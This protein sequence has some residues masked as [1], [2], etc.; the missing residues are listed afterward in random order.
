MFLGPRNLELKVAILLNK[1]HAKLRI[2][3][4]KMLHRL[5][6]RSGQV[7]GGIVLPEFDSFAEVLDP[8][9]LF[10]STE[11]PIPWD[12][13]SECNLLIWEW[14]WTSVPAATVLSI[15]NRMP[16]LKVLLFTGP[17]DRFWRGLDYRDFELHLKAGRASDAVGIMLR[18]MQS[19]YEYLLPDAFVFHMPVPVD[20]RYLDVRQSAAH[21]SNDIFLGAPVRFTGNASQLP[22]STFLAF[23]RLREFD[24]KLNGICFAYE[25]DEKIEAEKI[26]DGLGLTENIR[27]HTYMRPLVRFL[28]YMSQ[29]RIALYLPYS[30][31]QG[32]LAMMAA[33]VGLPVVTS[34]E[35]ETH[36]YLYPE[37]TVPWYEP[38][39]ATELARRLM[40]DTNFRQRTVETARERVGYYSVEHCAARMKQAIYA[41]TGKAAVKAQ[42]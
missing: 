31:V 9:P 1:N 11:E 40:T 27:I 26:I 10:L 33:A 34:S 12:R 24:D 3:T 22:I 36:R 41:I 28:D 13:L 21:K 37:T 2:L 4:K 32:R 19:H 35:I 15:R 5:Y 38:A 42:K 8:H 16:N 18:D 29:C 6:A 39:K 20:L 23:R 25:K 7:S 30:L 14:G 17:L